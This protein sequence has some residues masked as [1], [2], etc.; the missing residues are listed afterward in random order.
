[1]SSQRVLYIAEKDGMQGDWVCGILGC[2][3]KANSIIHIKFLCSDAN[4]GSALLVTAARLAKSRGLTY[5]KLESLYGAISFYIRWSFNVDGIGAKIIG[6]HN[7]LRD[8]TQFNSVNVS[9]IY[10]RASV[11]D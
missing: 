7:D 2:T 11:N 3:E 10:L 6:E 8:I 4:A 9:N 1:M 5:I